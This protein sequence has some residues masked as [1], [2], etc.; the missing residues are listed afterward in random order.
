MNSKLL[1]LASLVALCAPVCISS[2]NAQSTKLSFQPA[3]GPIKTM[4]VALEN[5]MA[6]DYAMGLLE[7]A[8]YAQLSRDLD[9]LRCE[10]ENRR[11]KAGLSD[12]DQ[13]KLT[14]KLNRFSDNLVVHEAER[15]AAV[16]L[17][18]IER[19]KPPM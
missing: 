9:G 15:A 2:A 5:K 19:I 1:R 18:P 10:E 12:H 16:V 4:E 11:L 13:R 6:A 7:S 8:E 14:V 17:R 3:I